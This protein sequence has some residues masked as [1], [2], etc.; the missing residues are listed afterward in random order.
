MNHRIRLAGGLIWFLPDLRVSLPA[1]GQRPGARHAVLPLRPLAPGGGQAARGHDQP[2]LP[3]AARGRPGRRG[4]NA[5]RVAGLAGL[6]AAPARR[7]AA[8]RGRPGSPCRCC[9]WRASSRWP[10]RAARGLPARSR[11][12]AGR[13]RRH[14]HVLGGW[15]PHQPGEPGSRHR[16]PR[17]PAAVKYPALTGLGQ[18]AAR[19]SAARPPPASCWM[20][21]RARPV[22]LNATSSTL[23][24]RGGSAGEQEL[25]HGQVGGVGDLYVALAARHGPDRHL[26]QVAEHDTAVVGRRRGANPGRPPPAGMPRR[27]PTAGT[28][29]ASGSA[30]AGR[31]AASR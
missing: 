5:G 21:Q 24:G 26:R 11:P 7:L 17:R 22:V 12:A 25:G 29:A 23:E 10:R 14:A 9:T 13:A 28:P 3:G 20:R 4:R 8:D 30:A 2:A 18:L 31:G 16:T 15:L 1:A 6:A 19:L 27:S